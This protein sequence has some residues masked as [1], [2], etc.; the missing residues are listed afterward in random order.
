MEGEGKQCHCTD[1]TGKE[2][3]WGSGLTGAVCISLLTQQ[4]HEVVL[5]LLPVGFSFGV[6]Y[7]TTTG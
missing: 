3:S 6:V 2:A 1:S 4:L 7:Q 5:E